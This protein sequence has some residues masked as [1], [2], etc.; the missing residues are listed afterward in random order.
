MMIRRDK[1]AEFP[2]PE[3]RYVAVVPRST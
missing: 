3:L 1:A 2:P